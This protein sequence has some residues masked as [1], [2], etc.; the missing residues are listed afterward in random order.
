MTPTERGAGF[1]A[2]RERLGMTAQ[3][4]GASIL[5]DQVDKIRPIQRWESGGT[6]PRQDVLEGYT[7]LLERFALLPDDAS[8][9]F[10]ELVQ[11]LVDKRTVFR[12]W[13]KR[14]A[15]VV[16]PSV[17]CLM[18]ADML[19]HASVQHNE[20]GSTS[21]QLCGTPRHQISPTHQRI[22]FRGPQGQ[23]VRIRVERD[24]S[25]DAQLP[26]G[27]VLEQIGPTKLDAEVQAS[28]PAAPYVS[29]SLTAKIDPATLAAHQTWDPDS[30]PGPK[31]KRRKQQ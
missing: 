22:V 17:V 21:I 25:I 12:A 24:G 4:V 1:R 29:E 27:W 15:Q 18:P 28:S 2:I 14:L 26:M 31:S 10:A 16:V 9:T 5:P 23:R 13:S 30:A 8:F 6:C 19:R 3:Q 7:E 20:D 11:Q